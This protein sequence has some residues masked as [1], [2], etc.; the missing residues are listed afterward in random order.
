MR[1]LNA[2]VH[3]MDCLDALRAMA[4]DSVDITVTSPPYN[5]LHGS[6]IRGA[7]LLDTRAFKAKIERHGYPDDRPEPEYQA[8]LRAVVRECLRVSRGLVWINH[9][10]RYRRGE[11]IHPARFLPFPIYSEV[12]WARQGS[13]A[14]NCQRFAPSHEAVWGFG[15][16]HWWNKKSNTLF[17]VWRI[18]QYHGQKDHPCPF[19]IELP[20]R[21]IE[22]SCPP[23]GVVFDPFAGIGTTGVA[24]L[25]LGRQFIGIEL[26]AEFAKIARKRLA[27][28]ETAAA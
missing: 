22:A 19:P 7:G 4:D 15:K 6:H 14:L 1:V 27:E 23:D 11:A 12:I 20:R 25:E 24:A 2:M 13:M 21:L 28:V 16:P 5:Q 18:S 17:S 8:W 9:K 26:S 10:I 3:R